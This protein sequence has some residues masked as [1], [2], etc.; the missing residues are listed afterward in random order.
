[1]MDAGCH[2]YRGLV[3]RALDGE[4]T[5]DEAGAFEAHVAACADC[6]AAMRDGRAWLESVAAASPLYEAPADLRDAVREI[7]DAGGAPPAPP[8]RSRLARVALV[9]RRGRPRSRAW[10]SRRTSGT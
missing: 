5:P 6:R 7:V 1:M 3:E 2:R 10:R 9:E 8:R 4:L